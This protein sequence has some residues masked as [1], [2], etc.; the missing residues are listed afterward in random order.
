[1]GIDCPSEEGL[2]SRIEALVWAD[3]APAEAKE[4][5]DSQVIKCCFFSYDNERS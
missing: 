1:M 2:N 5:I 4:R 3:T